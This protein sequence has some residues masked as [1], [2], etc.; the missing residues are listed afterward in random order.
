M[1]NGSN[2][3]DH[4]S[5]LYVRTASAPFLWVGG[6][7]QTPA[8]LPGT[9][10]RREATPHGESGGIRLWRVGRHPSPATR[11]DIDRL[12]SWRLCGGEQ[13]L[14]SAHGDSIRPVRAETS[15]GQR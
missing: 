9:L 14:R 3:S 15:R 1:V 2:H 12:C 6:P 11:C 5:H 13:R 4:Y 10:E 8:T 7:S